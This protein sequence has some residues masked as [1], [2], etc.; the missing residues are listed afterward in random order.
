MHARLSPE[1]PTLC[2]GQTCRVVLTAR[3]VH[4]QHTHKK[5]GAGRAG[6]WTGFAGRNRTALRPLGKESVNSAAQRRPWEG[7]VSVILPSAGS[8]SHSHQ[9]GQF[10]LGFQALPKLEAVTARSGAGQSTENA[11]ELPRN[12]K[13]ELVV[14]RFTL[15][16]HLVPNAGKSGPFLLHGG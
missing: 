4:T 9:A 5:C 3:G 16:G 1:S 15:V 11:A 14:S 8:S 10:P 6:L 13:R 12:E 7:V 2:I